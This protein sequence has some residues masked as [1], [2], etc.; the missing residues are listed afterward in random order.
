ML[1]PDLTLTLGKFTLIERSRL[2]ERDLR[3]IGHLPVPILSPSLV[4]IK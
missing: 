1:A 4:A 3:D 2:R